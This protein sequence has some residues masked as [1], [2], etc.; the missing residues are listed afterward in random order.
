[1]ARGRKTGG[2]KKGTPNI[3]TTD[4]KNKIVDLLD[5]YS[6]DQMLTDLMELKPRERL[7]LFATL[8][9]FITPKQNR[10]T[11]ENENDVPGSVVIY[12]PDNGRQM[13]S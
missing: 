5:R 12:M 13:T 1:M 10:T 6:L 8:A 7:K 11:I 9:E 4:V 2:R 3:L